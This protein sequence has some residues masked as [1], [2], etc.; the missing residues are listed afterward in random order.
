[1]GV[2]L[3]IIGNHSIPFKNKGLED[4]SKLADLLNS[5][6]LEE[7]E[8]IREMGERWN[9]PNE[10]HREIMSKNSYEK[11]EIEAN[12]RLEQVFNIHSWKII[13]YDDEYSD[14]DRHTDSKE[15]ELE[16]P[17]GLEL[18]INKYFFEFSIWGYRWSSWFMGND[19]IRRDEWRQIISEISTILG[20]NYV[21]YFPDSLLDFADYAPRN[22]YFPKEMEE[23]FQT[24]IKD[25]DQAIEVISQKWSKPMTLA[26]GDKEY[27]EGDKTPF[28]IDKFEDLNKTLTI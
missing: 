16:G 27:Q 6:K 9:S 11:Y 20:G 18:Y 3:V 24:E 21:M 5:L 8:F 13:D 23:H 26:E 10:Y 7:S 12:Q 19:V 22:Y 28:I 17:F 15:Y 1:M 25:L 4:K 2:D 14:E